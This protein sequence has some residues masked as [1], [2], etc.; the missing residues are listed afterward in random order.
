M[1]ALLAILI[2]AWV[3]VVLLPDDQDPGDGKDWWD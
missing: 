3:L 2:A 1:Q